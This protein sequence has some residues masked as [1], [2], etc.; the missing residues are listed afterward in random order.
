MSDT[1]GKVDYIDPDARRWSEAVEAKFVDLTRYLV[2]G[3]NAG[4]Q[5]ALDDFARLAKEPLVCEETAY[6][7]ETLVRMLEQVKGYFVR[8]MPL[9]ILCADNPVAQQMLGTAVAKLAN[10]VEA[11]NV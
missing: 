7:R 1:Q 4:L 3:D 10:A 9:W 8:L 2:Q 11:H 6:D 5:D